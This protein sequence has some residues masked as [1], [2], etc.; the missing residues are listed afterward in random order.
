[1]IK[2]TPKM[3]YQELQKRLNNIEVKQDKAF[4]KL[5]YV[6]V[7]RV[8]EITR[9]RIQQTK[10]VRDNPPITKNDIEILSNMIKI[11]LITEKTLRERTV[12]VMRI[13]DDSQRYFK[14]SEEWLT[15]DIIDYVCSHSE[16][17]LFDKSTRWGQNIFKKYFPEYNYHIHL[18]RH[19][20]ATHLLQGTAT[21]VPVPINIVSKMGGWSNATVLSLIYDGTIVEDYVRVD[22]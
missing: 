14:K 19:W 11:N 5:V 6:S 9:Y 7:A 13:A 1:M 3:A 18:L 22:E 15:K 4:L 17:I 16:T 21:G 2:Q 8:G 20:R 10:T 12:P